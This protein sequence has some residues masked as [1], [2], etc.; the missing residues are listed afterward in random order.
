[1]GKQVRIGLVLGATACL[2][3]VAADWVIAARRKSQQA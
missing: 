3:V 1:V 2:L